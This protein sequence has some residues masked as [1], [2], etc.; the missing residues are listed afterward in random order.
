MPIKIA[1]S[2]NNL[3]DP[4]QQIEI[5]NFNTLNVYNSD[6]STVKINLEDKTKNITYFD[7]N[8]LSKN[9]S[10]NIPGEILFYNTFYNSTEYILPINISTNSKATLN[11]HNDYENTFQ[12][13]SNI[14]L[15]ISQEYNFENDAG[16]NIRITHKGK[17]I[18]ENDIIYPPYNIKVIFEDT[19]PINL[20]GL[21][22][23][24]LRLWVNDDESNSLI[25]N[26]LFI[27][28]DSQ[29]TYK[30]YVEIN[31]TEQLLFDSNN[32]IK[33]QAW[34]ILGESNVLNLNFNTYNNE[35]I[36]NV[37]NF[38]N[39]FSTTTNF[40]FHYSNS[41]LLNAKIDIYTLNGYKVKTITE[42]N[43]TPSNNTFYKINQS[44][45]GRDNSNN[46]LSNGTYIYK[47]S[48]YLNSNNELV[49]QKFHKISKIK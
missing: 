1:K 19:N 3:I 14:D 20:S 49:Y 15:T 34:D 8:N 10:Y 39:P 11:I 44:W 2:T 30:G 45:D 37:Y 47:L 17:E 13:I 32:N 16:P 29:N 4:M 38:P 31:L 42:N 18:F 21:N 35:S 46:D 25:L 48:I 43:I 26:D 22:N 40:T 27:P 7:E 33:I 28:I 24:N 36:Y 9:L 6:L 12:S 5:A 41:E 23:N